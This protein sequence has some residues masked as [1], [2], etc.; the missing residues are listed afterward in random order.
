M[1]FEE[2]CSALLDARRAAQAQAIDVLQHLPT[3]LTKQ[4]PAA[5]FCSQ[6]A[7]AQAHNIGALLNADEAKN[8]SLALATDDEPAVQRP[9]VERIAAAFA[10]HARTGEEVAHMGKERR[11]S[12]SRAYLGEIVFCEGGHDDC[13]SINASVSMSWRAKPKD[14]ERAMSCLSSDRATRR[15]EGWALRF[16]SFG[17][18][19]SGQ[20]ASG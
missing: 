17:I 14:S 10:P 9:I 12:I 18:P 20:E 5:G 8:A 15:Q 13:P 11:L 6:V 4:T 3:Q 16:S 7:F 19:A 2:P 1:R